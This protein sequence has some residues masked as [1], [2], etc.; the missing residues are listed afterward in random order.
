[1]GLARDAAIVVVAG[2]VEAAG[3]V[4]CVGA[5]LTVDRSG[6]AQEGR[7]TNKVRDRSA[8]EKRAG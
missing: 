2:L 7:A 3:S 8:R 1:M 5:D 6:P 4:G